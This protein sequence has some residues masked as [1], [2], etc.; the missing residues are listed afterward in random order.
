MKQ[1][2]TIAIL[3]CSIGVSAQ[4]LIFSKTEP[5]Q[6]SFQVQ[7][8][9]KTSIIDTVYAIEDNVPVRT[10]QKVYT[11]KDST[12]YTERYKAEYN[13]KKDYWDFKSVS[14]NKGVLNNYIQVGNGFNF[15]RGLLTPS[16]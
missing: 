6:I 16:Y 5:Y 15:P 1:I 14:Y 3:L 11:L 12:K 9:A 8:I 10:I 4:K 2:I 7:G 13:T